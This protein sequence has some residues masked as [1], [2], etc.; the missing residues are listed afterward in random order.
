MEQKSIIPTIK[1]NFQALEVIILKNNDKFCS[2]CNGELE[3][4]D[5]IPFSSGIFY[6]CRQCGKKFKKTN[7]ID[8]QTE[9]NY[10]V[11]EEVRR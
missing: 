5:K 11:L 3:T 9:E 2:H 1:R 10:F 8:F 4:N 6:T 7:Y